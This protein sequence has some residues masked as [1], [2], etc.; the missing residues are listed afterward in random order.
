MKRGEISAVTYA[1]SERQYIWNRLKARE[2]A[3]QRGKSYSRR[4]ACNRYERRDNL[5]REVMI[6]KRA[7]GLSTGKGKNVDFIVFFFLQDRKYL[8]LEKSRL[9]KANLDWIDFK[10]GEKEAFL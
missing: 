8:S 10:P 6:W 4:R 2:N 5:L 9:K 1:I 3:C 7:S